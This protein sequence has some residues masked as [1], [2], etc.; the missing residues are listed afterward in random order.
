MNYKIGI[1]EDELTAANRLMELVSQVLPGAVFTGQKQ[2]IEEAVP[3]LQKQ[4]PDLLF[5]DVQ[6][7]DGNCFEIFKQVDIQC[8]VIFT[9]AYDHFAVNAF[10]VH[11]LDYL[12]K[13]IKFVE[14]EAS[15]QRFVQQR[16]GS[17]PNTEILRAFLRESQNVGYQQRFMLKLG[18]KINV[19]ETKDIAFIYTQ[20]KSTFFMMFSGKRMAA[21]HSL[22]SLEQQLDPQE[23]FRANRQFIVHIRAI[24][25][26]H[27]YSKSRLKIVTDPPSPELI[28]VSSERSPAFKRWVGGGDAMGEG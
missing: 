28:I 21:D 16:S 1:I 23:F 4:Q 13:P 14:L 19:V 20:A 15:I 25:E 27:I 7:A 18:A 24:K 3:W 26:M 9:T 6:L 8:P 17:I 22:E 12:L 11:A 2:S 10:R 5:M